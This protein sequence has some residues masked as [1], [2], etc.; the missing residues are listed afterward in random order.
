MRSGSSLGF[1]Y[2]AVKKQTPGVKVGK[3]AAAL[4]ISCRMSG[5]NRLKDSKLAL[6]SFFWVECAILSPLR[7][8]VVFA[9][10]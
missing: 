7:L 1:L 9:M 2:V 3:E 5:G 4:Q 8:I 10:E 6:V